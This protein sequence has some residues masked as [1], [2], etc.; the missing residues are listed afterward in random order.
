MNM[1]HLGYDV[2]AIAERILDKFGSKSAA[3]HAVGLGSPKTFTK[4]LEGQHCSPSTLTHLIHCAESDKGLDEHELQSCR[5]VRPPI[6]DPD[7]PYAKSRA[8]RPNTLP[9]ELP[10]P[11]TI[12]VAPVSVWGMQIDSCFGASASCLT[13]DSEWIRPLVRCGV[14]VITYKTVRSVRREPHHVPSNI[15]YLAEH[16]TD[17]APAVPGQ[18][19]DTLYATKEGWRALSPGQLFALANSLGMPSDE[20]ADWARDLRRLKGWLPKGKLLLVSVVGTAP[21]AD[22]KPKEQCEAE[23]AADFVRCVEYVLEME[24]NWPHGIELNFSCPNTVVA[25]RSVFQ[26]PKLAG[27]ICR[28][29]REAV[30]RSGRPI[31]LVAKIGYLDEAAI[32]DFC[33]ATLPYLDGVSAINTIPAKICRLHSDGVERPSFGE[34]YVKAGV[35]GVILQ[36]CA[37][38]VIRCLRTIF[39]EARYDGILIGMGGIAHPADVIRY[40]EAGA[41]L[42]QA[43]TAFMHNPTFAAEVRRLLA[44]AARRTS[45]GPSHAD[46][47]RLVGGEMLR[48]DPVLRDLASGKKGLAAER[49]TP[50]QA[51]ASY[52][53]ER[54]G[55]GSRT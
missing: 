8:R 24:D 34:P 42:V 5:R 35:S 50:E 6:W 11:G 31:R 47:V 25:E 1:Y 41:D 39:D 37:L 19:P 29:A 53:R 40:R 10:E 45:S 51:I 9:H 44:D 27:D 33:T 28:A 17:L 22:D 15:V 52:I 26:T 54:Y 38:E 43:T 16:A 7:S 2:Q 21:S 13:C 23:L 49:L 46:L 14:D 32:R 3:A 30:D 12:P 36:E 18:F 4:I 20:P 48:L 55:D